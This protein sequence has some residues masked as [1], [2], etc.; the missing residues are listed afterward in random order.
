MEVCVIEYHCTVTY[1]NIL[2]AKILKE[3]G[4]VEVIESTKHAAIFPV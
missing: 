3:C 4:Y 1:N 2:H